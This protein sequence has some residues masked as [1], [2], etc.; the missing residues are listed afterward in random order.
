MSNRLDLPI[1]QE[2][3]GPAKMCS[4]FNSLVVNRSGASLKKMGVP[5]LLN[6]LD[7]TRF[8]VGSYARDVRLRPSKAVQYLWTMTASSAG[9][10]R[11]PWSA[12]IIVPYV[13]CLG[14]SLG[15]LSAEGLIA[16]ANFAARQPPK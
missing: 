15:T 1:T 11:R 16:G 8:Y 5:V 9:R 12:T 6:A 7:S 13:A 4:I 10:K 14:G 2:P 3:N